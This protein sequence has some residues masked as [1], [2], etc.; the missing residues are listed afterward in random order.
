MPEKKSREKG[1][2]KLK[3]RSSGSE[4]DDVCGVKQIKT[5]EVT[6]QLVS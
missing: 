1:S 4:S 5:E 3:R 2:R 6:S